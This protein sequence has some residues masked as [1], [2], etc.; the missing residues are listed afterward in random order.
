MILAG[1]ARLRFQVEKEEGGRDGTEASFAP[2]SPC[3]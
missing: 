2:F 1:L 3:H